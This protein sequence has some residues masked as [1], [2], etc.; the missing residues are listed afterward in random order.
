MTVPS[1]SGARPGVLRS[2][3]PRHA[4]RRAVLPHGQAVVSSG[5]TFARASAPAPAPAMLQ[6]I[7]AM[8][9]ID[10]M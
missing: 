7:P 9:A 8:S 2:D 1:R 10:G 3:R 6:V 4:A 5:G